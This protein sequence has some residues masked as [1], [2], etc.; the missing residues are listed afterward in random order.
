MTRMA[1]ME[2]QSGLLALAATMNS[3]QAAWKRWSMV[4]CQ[5][6]CRSMPLPFDLQPSDHHGP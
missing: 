2:T 5:W 6:A 4:R 3:L 1:R